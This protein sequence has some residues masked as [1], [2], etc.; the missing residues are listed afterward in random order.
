MMHVLKINFNL[1]IC[2]SLKATFGRVPMCSQG[3]GER[4]QLN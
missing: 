4:L 1:F 3:S 2:L